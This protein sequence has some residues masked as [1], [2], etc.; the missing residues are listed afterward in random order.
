MPLEKIFVRVLVVL[1]GVFLVLAITFYPPQYAPLPI[2][3]LMIFILIDTLLPSH[4]DGEAKKSKSVIS[5]I[6]EILLGFCISGCLAG[7]FMLWK[8]GYFAK[9]R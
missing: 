3:F 5:K 4:S 2:V 7:L 6:L 1:A 9:F 8:W